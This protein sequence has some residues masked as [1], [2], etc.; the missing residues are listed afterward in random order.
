[1]QN[2]WIVLL[3]PIIVLV[4]SFISRKLNPSLFIGIVAAALIAHSGSIPSSVTLLFGRFFEELSSFDNLCLYG[5]LLVIGALIVLLNE[6]GGAHAFAHAI[7]KRI[8]NAKSAETSSL[9]ISMILFIDDYL[10]NLTVGYVM[11]PLTDSFSIARV[12]LAYL[13]RSLSGPLVILVPVSS[14]VA[15][16]TSQ[17]DL[18]G[19]HPNSIQTTKIMADPFYIYL[20]SIPFIFY[21]FL[22]IASVWLIVRRSLSFGPMY[23]HEQI[24]TTTGN[25]FGGK[26]ALEEDVKPVEHTNGSVADL[27]LPIIILISGVFIGIP[28]AGGF[29]SCNRS[30]LE[31]F[32]NNNKTFLVLLISSVITLIASTAFALLRKKITAKQ[33]PTI[34]KQGYD[35]MISAIVM[36]FLASVLGSLLKNDLSVGTFIAQ[37]ALGAINPALLPVMF[38]IV[39]MFVATI[40]GTSWGT[41]ALLV[42][43]MVQ[44]ITVYLQVPTPTC[45]DQ[46]PI[47][48]PIL[49]AIFSGAVCGNHISPISDTSIM[50]ST[51]SG[52]YPLDHAYTQL[53][54]TI[55]VIIGTT[56]SFIIT[57]YA[58]SLSTTAN[59][60]LS[61][62]TGLIISFALL[63]IADKIQPRIKS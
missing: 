36:V 2:S 31:S 52:A 51:S 41:I 17:L 23:V 50:A 3:P 27:I 29:Y 59:I 25:L 14:W 39:S 1:M 61:F 60:A 44:M 4:C 15:M 43:T 32:Q 18:A 6:N 12:K 57:G 56:I 20:K 13:V 55:P 5:F 24:A 63:Y 16:I 62:G 30:L 22:L 21:S 42:P 54:Y 48:F 33:L 46:L 34:A 49:G 19:I 38:F 28:L 45:P 58:L 35:L 26:P 8:T 11:R 10:S 40:T 47:L 37:H 7:T 9:L 53:W